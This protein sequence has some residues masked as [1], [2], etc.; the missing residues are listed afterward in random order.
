MNRVLYGGPHVRRCVAKATVFVFLYMRCTLATPGE[1][2]RVP[3][4]KLHYYFN[5]L[6]LLGSFAILRT[7][8]WS[9]ITDTVAWCVSRSV[10]NTSE[11]NKNS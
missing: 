2:V 11:A 8:V 4:V 9:I 3:Y 10:C 7:Y 5:Q 6:S 1:Y